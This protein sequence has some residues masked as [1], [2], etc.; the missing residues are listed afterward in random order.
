MI[1]EGVLGVIWGGVL[2]ILYECLGV[3]GEVCGW[4]VGPPS[5]SSCSLVQ[6]HAVS[7]RRTP[8]VTRIF[9]SQSVI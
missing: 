8:M 4:F 7:S 9:V 2:G 6:F 3:T 1:T 5:V